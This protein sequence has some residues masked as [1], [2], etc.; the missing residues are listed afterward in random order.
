MKFNNNQKKLFSLIVE[1]YKK[2]VSLKS[3][4][5][6]GRV[7]IYLYDVIS[8]YWGIGPQ[9]FIDALKDFGDKPVDLYINS[10]GGDVFDGRTM[11][12]ILQRH[13]G[14]VTAH[15]DGICAS[16][17]T[18]VACGAD[19]RVMGEGT[20]FMIHNAWTLAVGNAKDFAD[21]IDLLNE[22][23]GDIASDYMLSLIHI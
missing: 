8:E 10:P 5:V 17:A 1:N 4:L 19:K 23:D 14:E 16:A 2:D 7:Q 3:E 20:R 12:N 21:V 11:K 22:L 18:T 13:P 9:H 15:I 6:D